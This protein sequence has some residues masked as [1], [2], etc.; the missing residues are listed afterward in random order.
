MNKNFI[1][2]WG[3]YLS[4]IVPQNLFFPQPTGKITDNLFTICDRDTNIFIFSTGKDT[5][6][7]DAGYINNNYLNDEFVKIGIKPDSI[8]HLFLTHTDEDH[9]GALDCDSNSDWLNQ[10]QIYLGREEEK[11]ITKKTFRKFLFRT[12]VTI[13]RKYN[14]LDDGNEIKAGDIMVKAI[15]TPGHTSG[16]MSYLI[17]ETIL[18]TG[19]L[20]ILKNDRV[21]PFYHPWN[22]NH[23]QLTESIQK[24]THLDGIELLCTS[25]C[26]YTA[27][28]KEAI[29]D[30]I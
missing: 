30:W 17:N 23:Q 1:Y 19:D 14:L 25:H 28:F 22:Q 4:N 21:M 20:L 18:I 26:R 29:Q 9:A 2:F 8:A 13:S 15:L 6:C 7:I 24:I 3:N 27:N 11:L 5:I 10:A 16:H 12:P